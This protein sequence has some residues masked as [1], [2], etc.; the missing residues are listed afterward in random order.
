MTQKQ[1]TAPLPPPGAALFERICMEDMLERRAGEGG[2]GTLAEKRLHAILKKYICEDSTYHEVGVEGRRFVSDVR[3]GNEIYEI[4][5]GS[6]YPMRQKIEYY[7]SHTDCNVTV[8]HPIYQRH[9]V[10]WVDPK[11]SII[12][13]PSRA[14][15]RGRAEI[16]LSEAAGLMPSFPNPRLRFKLLFLEVQDYRMLDGRGPDRKRHAVKYERIPTALLAEEDFCSPADF[17]RLL[18]ESLS[19]VFPVKDFAAATHLRSL[20]AY[21][22]VRALEALGLIQQTDPIGRAKAY[23]RTQTIEST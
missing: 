6:F 7:L 18:P 14:P 1:A 2:I 11:T 21:S 20:D 19:E 23:R 8:V 22:A 3:V 16:L 13:P 5:T 12:S 15:R 10:L 9:W 17:A 4:Q